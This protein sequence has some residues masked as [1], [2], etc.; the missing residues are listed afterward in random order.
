MAEWNNKDILSENGENVYVSWA[1][2]KIFS[3]Y[4]KIKR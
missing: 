2:P 4:L 1:E 3:N